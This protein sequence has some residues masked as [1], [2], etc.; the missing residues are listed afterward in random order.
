MRNY[1]DQVNA[2][3]GQVPPELMASVQNEL[4]VAESDFE[5]TQRQLEAFIAASKIQMLACRRIQTQQAALLDTLRQGRIDAELA[6]VRQDLRRVRM[7]FEQLSSAETAPALAL[8]SEQT[9]RNVTA[10]TAAYA[11][12]NRWHNCSSRRTHWRTGCAKAA[13]TARPGWRCNCSKPRFR[14]SPVTTEG[15][16]PARVGSAAGDGRLAQ[17]AAVQRRRSHDGADGRSATGRCGRL[18]RRAG[19]DPVPA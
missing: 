12:R 11:S 4:I 5:N 14:W 15:S 10:I 6:V 2:I 19:T 8:I 17:H 16:P 18:D 7:L 9:R 3:Y 13:S 1:V